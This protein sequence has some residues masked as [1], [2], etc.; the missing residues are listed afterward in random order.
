M[1]DTV[2]IYALIVG[3]LLGAS[4]TWLAL[5]GS[6]GPRRL[7]LEFVPRAEAV[8]LADRLAATRADLAG[9]SV[10]ADAL[11]EA[12]EH[13][14]ALREQT[15]DELSCEAERREEVEREVV[16]L[17][18][19]LRHLT[20]RL[21]GQRAEFA[22]L[23]EQSR[24][25]FANVSGKL[26]QS[27]G[28]A[29][30][31]EHTRTLR[32]LLDPVRTKLHE[33][34]EQVDRKFADETRDKAALRTQIEQLTTLNRG[35]SAEA[36]ALTA[37]LK[38][39]AKAQGDW[40][41]LQLERLLEAAGLSA[42]VHFDT[43]CS[44][45]SAGGSQQRPDCIV[46]LPGERCLVIDSKVS[47]TAYERFCASTDPAVAERELRSHVA[48][49]RTHVRDLGRKAYHDLHQIACPD[50]VLLFVPLEP[51]F[52]AAVRES[53]SLFTEALRADIVLVSPSTLLAT[54]RTVA[55]IW[56]QDDQR[57]NAEQ[58]AEVGRKL[59][60][61]F[62]G[63][64]E[65]MNAVGEQLERAQGSYD[66]AMDKLSRS[67]KRATTLIARADELRSLGVA[68]SKQLPA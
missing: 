43:Q 30:R 53:P 37:A 48:S 62:V 24:E 34:Q 13:S 39:D 1:P 23:R 58:I 44:F 66:R 19:E 26:L 14:R 55:Y 22:V 54:M 12:L 42:D 41:E 49:L 21:K 46:R 15:R 28:E 61:K 56:Q 35:L 7:A 60:D 51:A 64:V 52:I 29:L 27:S 3:G 38:G 63:F 65:D 17:R 20:E 36:A 4:L 45:R 16:G 32:E 25:E 9:A 2:L 67:P 40:G 10:Q 31:A 6:I 59:Y 11:Q 68:S 8:E 50:Y 18:A 33:F 57:A 47:L 5:R